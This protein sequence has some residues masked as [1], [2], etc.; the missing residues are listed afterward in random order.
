[1]KSN[2]KMSLIE[3]ILL[4]GTDR[5]EKKNYKITAD[6]AFYIMI[7]VSLGFFWLFIKY[8]RIVF[9][10]KSFFVFFA[11]VCAFVI[12]KYKNIIRKLKQ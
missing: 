2:E 3:K 8:S 6:I 4:K 5:A 9:L 1:M 11:F 7:F 12:R 10:Y